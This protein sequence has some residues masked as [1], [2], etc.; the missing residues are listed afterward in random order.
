[1][2]CSWLLS[3][4]CHHIKYKP[5]VVVDDDHDDDDD[6]DDIDVEHSKVSPHQV[7]AKCDC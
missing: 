2:K 6:D 1:M 5:S 3:A 4:R 7:Q